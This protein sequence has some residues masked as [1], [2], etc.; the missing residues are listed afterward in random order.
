MKRMVMLCAL[1]S[2]MNMACARQLQQ[3]TPQQ[4]AARKTTIL[5]KKLRLTANQVVKVK[6]IMLAQAVR[7][8][9]LRSHRLAGKRNHLVHKRILEQTDKGM[10]AVLNPDQQKAYVSWKTSRKERLS[11]REK[12]VSNP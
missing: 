8:D 6:S 1:I 2:V 7:I 12:Q 9:S 5:T 3:R 10:Y 11:N 4:R